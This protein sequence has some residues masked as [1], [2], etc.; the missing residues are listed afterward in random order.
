MADANMSAIFTLIYFAYFLSTNL[1]TVFLLTFVLHVA[2]FYYFFWFSSF[3]RQIKLGSHQLFAN[4]KHLIMG[5]CD[6]FV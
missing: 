4:A 6:V 1:F 3:V 2:P 5:R